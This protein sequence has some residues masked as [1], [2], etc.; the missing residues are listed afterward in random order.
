MSLF[1]ENTKFHEPEEFTV[2]AR[3]IINSEIIYLS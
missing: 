3:R 1:G 2:Q